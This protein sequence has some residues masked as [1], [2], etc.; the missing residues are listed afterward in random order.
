MNFVGQGERT[1]VGKLHSK[2]FRVENIIVIGAHLTQ[3]ILRHAEID[4]VLFHHGIQTMWT[5]SSWIVP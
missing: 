2:V 5:K 4:F 1:G 3:P